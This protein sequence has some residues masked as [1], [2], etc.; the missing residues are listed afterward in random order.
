MLIVMHAS[1]SDADV[2]AV[3]QKVRDLGF[4]PH[5]MPGAQRIAVAITGNPGPVDPGHFEHL[6]GV[7][8]DPLLDEPLVTQPVDETLLVPVGGDP[9]QPAH[10]LG[11]TLLGQPGDCAEVQHAEATVG[12]Q[13]DQ[14]KLGIGPSPALGRVP[15]RAHARTR[16]IPA[17]A[18]IATTGAVRPG[19]RAGR[20]PAGGF[21]GRAP[22]QLNATAYPPAHRPST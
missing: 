11:Q 20:S 13:G 10:R 7:D 4:Q 18:P 3:A 22:A 19:R 5:K 2:D 15:G 6:P 21:G 12:S 1:A 8:L 17:H 14:R 9:Q 16:V